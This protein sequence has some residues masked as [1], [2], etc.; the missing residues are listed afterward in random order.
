MAP[1]VKEVKHESAVPT[2]GK[3]GAEEEQRVP[4]LGEVAEDEDFAP[5]RELLEPVANRPVNELGEDLRAALKKR[6][7]DKLELLL[8]SFFGA[9]DARAE[10]AARKRAHVA[11]EEHSP[12]KQ[13]RLLSLCSLLTL[14][15]RRPRGCRRAGTSAA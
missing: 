6:G 14:R 9:C 3:R 4:T 10:E 1:P 13:L 11:S 5:L 8:A 2:A 7:G 15:R 12:G